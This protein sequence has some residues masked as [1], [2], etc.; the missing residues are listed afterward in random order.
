MSRAGSGTAVAV[1]AP[2]AKGGFGLAPVAPAI[3]NPLTKTG[4]AGSEMSKMW[5]PSKPV[6]TSWP[7]H[8]C[9]VLA[10]ESQV[11]TRMLP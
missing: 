10:G 9:V 4:F 8:E 3:R 11:R 6:P 1:W 7:P 2:Q 5:I